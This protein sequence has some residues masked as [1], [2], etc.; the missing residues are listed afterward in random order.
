MSL[1]ML[2]S[3]R[4]L[5]KKFA[6]LSKIILQDYVHRNKSTFN[7]DEEMKC[8]P[9]TFQKKYKYLVEDNRELLKEATSIREFVVKVSP[10]INF[11]NNFEYVEYMIRKYPDAAKSV[12][13]LTDIRM[14]LRSIS[15]CDFAGTWFALVPKNCVELVLV[16]DEH[17]LYKSL[18]DL[19]NLHLHYPYRYWYFKQ[20]VVT[21]SSVSVV[22]AVPKST[23]LYQIEQN[24]LLS[25]DII[26][27]QVGGEKI[28][29]LTHVCKLNTWF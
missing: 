1:Y 23:R 27:V 2:D 14:L 13:L 29:D 6:I 24:S 7:V 16:F 11:M 4:E 28:L 3:I 22:Y 26:C 8:L 20:M 17:W 15:L 25:N 12:C 21:S 10:S 18:E 9:L 19:R 5:E